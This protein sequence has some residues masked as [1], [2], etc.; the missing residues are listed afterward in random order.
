MKTRMINNL[1]CAL[2]ATFIFSMGVFA[3]GEPFSREINKDFAVTKDTRLEIANKYGNV[4]ILKR[5]DQALSIKVLIKIN[6]RD[7]IRAEEMM[8]MVHINISQEGELIRAT[9]DID[10]KA[11][12]F[13]GGFGN[14][15][16][17]L[18]INYTISMPNSVPLNLSNKYGNVFID[19]LISTSTIDV[20]YGKLTA[21]KLL[22]DSKDPLTKVFLSYSNGT[23][24]DTK[25]IEL[26][27]KYSKI[28][29]TNNKALAILSKYSKIYVTNGSS[30]VSE[31]KYD[32]YEIGKLNNLIT[33]AA[34]CHFEIKEL[35]GKLQTETKYTDVIINHIGPDFVSAKITNSYGT[36]KL[37]IDPA[38]SYTLNSYSKY[39][40]V[41]YPEENAKVSRFNENNE[42]KINGI[43]GNQQSP[44]NEVIINSNYGNIRLIP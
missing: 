17:G 13:F 10:D 1:S 41:A 31:S 38:A 27:I 3:Q 5:N 28:N 9:T 7:K 35:A 44:K 20:K 14:Q 11:G 36:Y 34:Y 2:F 25:W 39:C 4:D 16:D 15:S 12:R 40:S 8:R 29:I 24:Q 43:V 33:N 22:H 37:A 6:T 32:T 18:E 26:D 30:I 42:Q 21:N 19:E 23:I